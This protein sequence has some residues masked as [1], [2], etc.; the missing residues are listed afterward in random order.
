[1]QSRVM[2]CTYGRDDEEKGPAEGYVE[3]TSPPHLR[4]NPIQPTTNTSHKTCM[5]HAT[6]CK[7]E[8]SRLTCLSLPTDTLSTR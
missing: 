2:Y 7:D 8:E 6:T 3:M 5:I 4:K 1:M